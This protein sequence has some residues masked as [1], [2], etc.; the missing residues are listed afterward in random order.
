[1]KKIEK[2]EMPAILPVSRRRNTMLRVMLLQLEVG[3][4]LFL[5]REEWKA[6]NPP[7][8][9]VANIKKSHGFRFDYGFKTDGTGWLF[10][11][12]A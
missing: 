6:K 10:R 7:H 1:M 12:V 8:Y 9:V 2:D 11:R 5:P 4:G 3:E